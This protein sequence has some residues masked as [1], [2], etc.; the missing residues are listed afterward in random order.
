MAARGAEKHRRALVLVTDGE[1]RASYLKLEELLKYLR[2]IDVQVFAI[3]LV[4]ELDKQ[5]GFIRRSPREQAAKLLDTLAAETGGRVFYPK[6]LE[7][8]N[9]AVTAIKTSCTRNT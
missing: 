9:D 4:Q 7:Q 8:L 5:G 2:A 1:D 3:G 6:K